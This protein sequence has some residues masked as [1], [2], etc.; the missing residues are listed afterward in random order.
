LKSG[1]DVWH[2]NQVLVPPFPSAILEEIRAGAPTVEVLIRKGQHVDQLPSEGPSPKESL[3]AKE[4]EV[5]Q[6]SQEIDQ[7]NKEIEELNSDLVKKNLELGEKE[8]K[9]KT[10]TDRVAVLEKEIGDLRDGSGSKDKSAAKK[11]SA[12][13]SPSKSAKKKN[14]GLAR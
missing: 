10:L 12:K 9:I 3:V 11:T 5:L 7:K 2:E 1:S 8:D 4:N 13:K 6:K 14:S